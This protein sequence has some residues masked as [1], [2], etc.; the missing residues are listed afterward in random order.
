MNYEIKLSV[1]GEGEG[2]GRVWKVGEIGYR[3]KEGW[4]SEFIREIE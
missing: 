4:G 3:M 1:E 2:W